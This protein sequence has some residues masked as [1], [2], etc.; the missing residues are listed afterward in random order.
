MDTCTAGRGS[1]AAHAGFA[2]LRHLVVAA[3]MIALPGIMMASDPIT[4]ATEVKQAVDRSLKF[5]AKDSL[6]WKEE[7][8]CISCHHGALVAWATTEAK[9]RGHAVDESFLADL[10]AWI[11]Q[12][13][14]GARKIPKRPASAPKAM[15]YFAPNMALA[16]SADPS[17][18]AAVRDALA[19]VHK[20]VRGDQVADGSWVA[21]PDTR[22]PIFGPSNA[23]ATAF[24]I[25]ALASGADAES[26]ATRTR[27]LK[28]LLNAPPDTELQATTLRLIVS[29][30][31]GQP[32]AACAPLMAELRRR[33]RSD[34][35][36]AQTQD[37][38]SDAYATGQALYALAEAG[39]SVDDDAVKRGQSFLIKTQRPDGA[40]DMI[41]RPCPPTNKGAK[42]LIPIT[43]A[44]ASWAALGLV[45]SSPKIRAAAKQ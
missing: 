19:V 14:D 32:D 35:G 25:L 21:W 44:G 3:G 24:S 9:A 29:R 38:S 7:H 5:L 1:A 37:M 11:I 31:C 34:G 8:G 23:V 4:P 18:S 33:Q 20:T 10:V 6:A 28:W 42:N 40:W 43:G 41:S 17:P 27:G 13:G 39:A 36:W 16:L 45:R 22:A 30:R 15:N 2:W 12:S 26:Q